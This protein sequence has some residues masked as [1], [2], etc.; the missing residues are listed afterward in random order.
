MP[1]VADLLISRARYIGYAMRDIDGDHLWRWHG[2]HHHKDPLKVGGYYDG[3]KRVDYR[4]TQDKYAMIEFKNIRAVDITDKQTSTKPVGN[5][6]NIDAANIVLNNY[7]G[8]GPMELSYEADFGKTTGKE[9]ALTLGFE[10]SVRAMLRLGSDASP[11]GGELET[12]ITATQEKAKT[13]SSG[14]SENRITDYPVSAPPGYDLEY[15][16]TRVV[17]DMEVT[18]TGKG[19]LEHSVQLGKHWSGKWK[20]NDG[21]HGKTWPRWGWWASV[22]DLC[23]VLKG[24]G[25]RDQFFWEHFH[26]HPAPQWLIDRIM[27]PPAMPFKQT[28]RYDGSTRIELTPKTLRGPKLESQRVVADPKPI[29]LE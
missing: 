23:E 1:D 2:Y 29:T 20:G 12:T 3:G 18:I 10:Q 21:E 11:V 9:D 7:D 22:E 16:G 4:R 13:I 6:R 14:T 15:V 5:P 25:A 28:A 26:S 8:L 17:Q 27:V 24:N 19:Q